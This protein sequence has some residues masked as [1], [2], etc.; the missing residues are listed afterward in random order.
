MRIGLKLSGSVLGIFVLTASAPP[1]GP[2]VPDLKACFTAQAAK[3]PFQGVVAARHGNMAIGFPAGTIDGAVVPNVNTRYRL[4]SVGK[5]FTQIAIGQ[6]VDA[7]RIKLDDPIGKYLPDLPAALAAVTVDQLVHHTSGVASNTMFTPDTVATMAG[8]RTARDL[9]P[10]VVNEPLAFAPGTQNRYSNGGY[11][12]L[13]AIIEAVSGKSYG[14]YLKERIFAPLGMGSSSL[15]APA[16]TAPPMSLLAGPGQPPL[17]AP[18]R[19]TGVPEM[20]GNPAGDAVSTAD[21]LLKV[22]DALLGDRLLSAAVKTRLFARPSAPGQAPGTTLT[23]IGQ[24]GGRPGANVYL[25][26]YPDT[27]WVLAVLTNYDPPAGELMG[28][29]F[30]RAAARQ[31][32]RSA[33]RRRPAFAASDNQTAA[34]RLSAVRAPVG[35]TLPRRVEFVAVEPVQAHAD[36]VDDGGDAVGDLVAE[37]LVAVGPGAG[38]EILVHCVFLRVG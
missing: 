29:S 2:S 38:Q 10:L 16:G 13:G 4:A 28:R 7:G 9:L 21:D 18:A 1:A 26:A 31:G 22:G 30:G 3:T 24:A 11:F 37:M 33:F 23:S 6:L 17:S 35:V 14:D 8:A 12:I 27:G 36:R 19:F 20:A 5:V 25:M 15:V 34:A 32:V